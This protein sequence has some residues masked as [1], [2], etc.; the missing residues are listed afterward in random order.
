MTTATG[1]FGP[2][3]IYCGQRE[4]IDLWEI[5]SG[6]SFMFDTCCEGMHDEAIGARQD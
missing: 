3:C 2:L 5:W 4:R 1:D 6:H